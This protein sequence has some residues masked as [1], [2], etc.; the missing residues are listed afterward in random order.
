MRNKFPEMLEEDEEFS[1][2]YKDNSINEQQ[3]MTTLSRKT[4]SDLISKGD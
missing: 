2:V 3:V 1:A 4:V